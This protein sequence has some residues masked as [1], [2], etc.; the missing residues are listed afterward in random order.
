MTNY[1]NTY[2]RDKMTQGISLKNQVIRVGSRKGGL[3]VMS[4]VSCHLFN[5]FEF[6][7]ELC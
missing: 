5:I 2:L 1:C 6:I 7:I 3:K 4:K